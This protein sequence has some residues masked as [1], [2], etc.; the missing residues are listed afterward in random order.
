[1]RIRVYD[2]L[3]DIDRRIREIDSGYYIVYNTLKKAYEV[4]HSMQ[5]GGSYCLTL[6]HKQLDARAVEYVLKTRAHNAARFFEEMESEN[7]ANRDRHLREA[8]HRLAL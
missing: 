6:P 3:Y 7:Q 1:M 2:D 8:A 5:M 4:H